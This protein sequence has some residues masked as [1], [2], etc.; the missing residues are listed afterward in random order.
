MTERG[1]RL[2]R[3][4][5][6]AGEGGLAVKEVSGFGAGNGDDFRRGQG[7][8]AIPGE[9]GGGSFPGR[10]R[11]GVGGGR[12]DADGGDDDGAESADGH[13]GVADEAAGIAR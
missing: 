9:D 7:A 12:C 1:R 6:A 4:R 10:G 2:R 8:A 11:I 13:Q 3:R 5:A